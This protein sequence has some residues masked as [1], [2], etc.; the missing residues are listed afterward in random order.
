M[1]WP[2]SAAVARNTFRLGV[3]APVLCLVSMLVVQLGVAL[4]KPLF[5]PL[6]VGGVTTLRLSFAGAVLLAATR[7]R[8]RGKRARDLA[9][10]AVL[11]AASGLMALLFAAAVDRIPMGMAATIEFLGPLSV[12]L[13][14]S[15]RLLDVG[16]AALAAGGVVLL[17][18]LGEGAGGGR[19]DPVGLLL[20]FAAAGCF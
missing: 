17:A 4:S 20:A 15:R 13:A 12:A 8:L 2:N 5:G 14:L 19:V 16:W 1:S 18:L 10:V 7:P 6:G 3:P 11:G 9:A